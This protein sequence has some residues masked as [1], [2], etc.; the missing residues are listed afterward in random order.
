LR[1]DSVP[2]WRFGASPLP[3]NWT[4]QYGA[5]E[6]SHT[7]NGNRYGTGLEDIHTADSKR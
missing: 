5:F 2:A 4:R 7:G 6:P 1:L 3:K